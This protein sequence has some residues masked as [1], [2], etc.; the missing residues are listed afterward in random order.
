MFSHV[1]A[2]SQLP[3]GIGEAVTGLGLSPVGTMFVI[4][5]IYVGLG[6]VLDMI[7]ILSLF[8]PLFIPTVAASGYS[9]I[10][11]G[12]FSV[13]LGELG[14]I[15]P[16]VGTNLYLTQSIDP[17]SKSGEVIRGAVPSYGGALI[18]SVLLVLFPNIALWLPDTMM[19]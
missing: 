10:W 11:F 8:V 14:L 1:I 12:T 18:L 17:D 2:I 19:R 6:C 15:T 13:L 7:A 4:L 3:A 5:G 16:P 9:L